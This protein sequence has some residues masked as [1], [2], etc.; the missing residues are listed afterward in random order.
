LGYPD[1]ERVTLEQMTE[2][3]GRIASRVE[4]PVSADI[5]AGY[6]TSI[7][8][9][10][11]AARTVLAAGAV[12]IN[13]QDSTGRLSE[14]LF[15][16]PAQMEK[17]TAIRAMA[18]SENIPLFINAR[19]D[20]CIVSKE[21]LG[22]RLRRAIERANA[23]RAAGADCIF[24]P[25]FGDLDREAIATLVKEIDA[26]LNIIVG[27]RT[28]SLPELEGI[29]VARVSFGPRPMRAALALIRRI[30]REWKATGTYTQMFGDTLSY[31]EVNQMLEGH[32]TS[33][34]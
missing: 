32:P 23:Y 9:V 8:G 18:C 14:P 15:D 31:A 13:L 11:N 4:I 16:Q 27:E 24:V 12:G 21:P 17:I 19:T 33:V 30:A 3:I 10:V 2:V 20:V 22:Q 25:D 28:P 7:D 5:E 34:D 1:G 26:P 6:A 29:G